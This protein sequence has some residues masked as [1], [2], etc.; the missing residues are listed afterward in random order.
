MNEVIEAYVVFQQESVQLR[1]FHVSVVL[2][3]RH[4]GHKE[5][6]RN[7]IKPTKFS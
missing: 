1:V 2:P 6:R 5:S 4:R 7:Y 3:Q